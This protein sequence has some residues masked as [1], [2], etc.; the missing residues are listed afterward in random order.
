M[1]FEY[2]SVYFVKVV[3]PL[4]SLYFVQSNTS[5]Q[6]ILY[7]DVD[8]TGHQVIDLFTVIEWFVLELAYHAFRWIIMKEA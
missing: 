4:V 3:L 8:I 6:W 2:V 7:W 5:I 1:W